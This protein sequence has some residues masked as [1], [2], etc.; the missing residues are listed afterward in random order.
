MEIKQPK[1]GRFDGLKGLERADKQISLLKEL[2]LPLVS[3]LP[4]RPAAFL[5]TSI[6]RNPTSLLFPQR[7][8]STT[9]NHMSTKACHLNPTKSNTSSTLL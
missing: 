5:L 9:P 6:H 7:P 1:P 4:S 8:L 3:Y 2:I